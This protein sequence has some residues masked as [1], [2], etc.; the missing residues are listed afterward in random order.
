MSQR[1]RRRDV[2]AA[3]AALAVS[4]STLLSSPVAA[5]TPAMTSTSSL[6]L[7]RLRH[8]SVLVELPGMRALPRRV[9]FDPSLQPS[10]S[11]QGLFS[12]PPSPRREEALGAL[13]LVCISSSDPTSFD[14]RSLA[15]LDTRRAAVLVPD[16]SVARRV[17]HLGL[18]KVRVMRPGDVAETAGLVVRASPGR[19]VVGDAI[20]FHI[21]DRDEAR[22]GVPRGLWH[23]GLLPPLE[24]DAAAS[25]FATLHPADVVL[26]CAWGL[27]LRAGG[28]PLLA[29]V[30]DA[31]TLA[32]L[33]G[34]RVL[35]P[36]GQEARPAGVFSL[37]WEAPSLASTTDAP[38]ASSVGPALRPLDRGAWHR[39]RPA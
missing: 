19:G 38:A 26:G 15:A 24:V 10:F 37:V 5:Q 31:T 30:L 35:V 1:L 25:T 4:T 11:M 32:R 22:A 6:R 20:G 2:L 18:T 21:V 34:A 27:R 9:L 36:L 39:V 8:T 16:D 7:M 29:D 33:A 12:A 17:R 28:P 23:T 3:G 14:P 13:D